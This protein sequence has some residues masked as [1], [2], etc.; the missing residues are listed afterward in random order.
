MSLK[1]MKPGL[2]GALVASLAL[3][4]VIAAARAIVA[5]G[6][7]LPNFYEPTIEEGWKK[8][9]EDF[10]FP[11]LPE[12]KS[13]S[14]GYALS[15]FDKNIRPYKTLRKNDNAVLILKS[16]ISKMIS[17][18]KYT[19]PYNFAYDSPP[20]MLTEDS[21]TMAVKDAQAVLR[22]IGFHC[23]PYLWDGMKDELAFDSHPRMAGINE[24][25]QAQ[26][27]ENNALEALRNAMRAKSPEF[28]A[29]E[30]E[31]KKLVVEFW[32]LDSIMSS[33]AGKLNA[34]YGIKMRKMDVLIRE[35]SAKD[36]EIKKLNDAYEKAQDDSKKALG[37]VPGDYFTVH[38][39]GFRIADEFRSR[40]RDA[41][42]AYGE[43][44]KQFL[45]IQVND[46][47]P[48]VRKEAQSLLD[49][50]KQML[51]AEQAEKD[52][53]AKTDKTEKVA[54]TEEPVKRE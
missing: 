28:K 9:K 37:K 1:R 40:L 52:K 19:D 7:H 17:A 6:Y 4:L 50:V 15:P 21:R 13:W 53:A 39:G 14:D 36:P 3:L 32:K 45:E 24:Y 18:L 2:H 31:I 51:K 46:R 26:L 5:D 41:I 35:H 29:H 11:E 20:W 33:E 12:G 16:A 30:E 48:I 8:L 42:V 10:K 43:K 25:R 54:K 23:L 44:S 22:E 49:R 38:Q 34:E 47:N 27:E